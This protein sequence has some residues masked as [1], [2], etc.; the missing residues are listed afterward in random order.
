MTTQ[1]PGAGVASGWVGKLPPPDAP[2]GVGSYAEL[3]RVP[4]LSVGS[5]TASP[6]YNDVQDPHR[7]DEV[8]FVSAGRAVI[9]LD[10]TRVPVSAGSIV[11]VPAGLPHRFTDIEQRLS[12]LVLFAPMET[13]R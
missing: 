9:D 1:E 5:F 10:G 4:A 3:L 8:Y 11:Y 7:E 13:A 6:G 2:P 12:V